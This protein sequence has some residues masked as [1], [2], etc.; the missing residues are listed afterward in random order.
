MNIFA[1]KRKT[2]RIANAMIG[3]SSLPDFFLESEMQAKRAEISALDEL[4]CLLC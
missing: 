1:M 4:N 2:A 3:K